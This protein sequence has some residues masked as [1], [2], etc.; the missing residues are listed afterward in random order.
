M[1]QDDLQLKKDQL[2][3]AFINVHS[4]DSDILGA[5]AHLGFDLLPDGVETFKEK[6]N[7]QLLAAFLAIKES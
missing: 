5:Y 7:D 2:L 3:W 4:S 6:E 1:N